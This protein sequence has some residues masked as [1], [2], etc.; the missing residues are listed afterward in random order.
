MR[1]T[2]NEMEVGELEYWTWTLLA[3]APALRTVRSGGIVGAI[4]RHLGPA[5]SLSVRLALTRLLEKGL[6]DQRG[7]RYVGI[8]GTSMSRA[9]KI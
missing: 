3:E 6:V 9:G 8:T 2:T 7:G 4:A 5:G 1:K